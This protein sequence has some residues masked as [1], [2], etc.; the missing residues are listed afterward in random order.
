MIDD[1]Q[2][3]MVV[4]RNSNKYNR[5]QIEALVEFQE[6]FFDIEIITC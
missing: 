6:R 1:N 3:K 5:Q 2:D 4:A